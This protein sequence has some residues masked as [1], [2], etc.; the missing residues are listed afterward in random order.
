MLSPEQALI[1][2]WPSRRRVSP[3]GDR[4]DA[5]VIAAF[6]PETDVA[7]DPIW[8]VIVCVG[9]P[10]RSCVREKKRPP[11]PP[12]FSIFSRGRGV[13]DVYAEVQVVQAV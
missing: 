1:I 7:V 5:G 9:A 4:V 8:P 2:C 11:P 3:A 10:L 13:E 6:S 12:H